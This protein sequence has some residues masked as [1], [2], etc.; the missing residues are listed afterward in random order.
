MALINTC[1]HPYKINRIVESTCVEHSETCDHLVI[2]YHVQG[3]HLALRSSAADHLVAES[4]EV[5]E[6]TGDLRELCKSF[7]SFLK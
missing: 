4:M 1:L 3:K 5:L 2:Q 7:E 6:R